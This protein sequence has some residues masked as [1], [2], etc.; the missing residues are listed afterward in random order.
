MIIM[1]TSRRV[2][3]AS[4]RPLG[5]ARGLALVAA[6]A[7]SGCAPPSVTGVGGAMVGQAGAGGSM[8]TVFRTDAGLVVVDLAWWGAAD[9]LRSMLAES[10]SSP[11]DVVAVLL[12]HAHR[13][14]IAAWPAVRGAVFH[15]ADAEAP[16]F[17]GEADYRGWVPRLADRL[18]DPPHPARHEVRVVTFSTDTTLVLGRDTIHAFLVPGHTP[19]STAYLVRGV[20]FAGDALAW[21]PLG[22]R[23]SLPG[24]SDDVAQAAASLDR[25]FERLTDHD[26]R[27]ICTGHGKCSP[28]TA[29][30]RSDVLGRDVSRG[31]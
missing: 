18:V 25:L 6:L 2:A 24:Y 30:F 27:L 12:T 5:T 28:F 8:F 14:H 15:M 4:L 10:G 1:G 19:G 22:F 31:P 21:T 16:H 11:D 26:V 3:F 9:E 23:P 17:F 20:V 7:L 13:D 29:A